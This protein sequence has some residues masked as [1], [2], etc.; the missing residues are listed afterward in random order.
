MGPLIPTDG[1]GANV[2]GGLDMSS[3]LLPFEWKIWMAKS[4]M[5]PF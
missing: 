5:V 2:E 4:R 1:G 3:S